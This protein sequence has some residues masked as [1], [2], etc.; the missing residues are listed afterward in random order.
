LL[1][2]LWNGR[3]GMSAQ[4]EKLDSISNNLANVSTEGYKK[5]EVSFS[6]LDKVIL[7]QRI[8]FH[9]LEQV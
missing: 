2:I 4:Q 8:R 6:D 1:R 9:Q 7:I 5:T 3:T